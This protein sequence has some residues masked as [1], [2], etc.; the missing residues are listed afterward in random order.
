[1][2]SKTLVLPSAPTLTK[3][4]KDLE[5]R[6]IILINDTK[7]AMQQFGADTLLEVVDTERNVE[8]IINTN[9]CENLKTSRKQG[10]CP[11]TFEFRI[12]QHKCTPTA[13]MGVTHKHMVFVC[14]EDGP[15]KDV[16]KHMEFVMLEDVKCPA[17]VWKLREMNMQSYISSQYYAAEYI[18][19]RIRKIKGLD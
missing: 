5:T 17:E 4:F 18:L 2:K 16:G 19:Q 8:Y 11:N 6:R 14:V 12:Q 13:V 7:D 1:M 9:P 10:R 15:L 3:Q